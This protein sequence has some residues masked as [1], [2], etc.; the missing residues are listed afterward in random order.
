[1]RYEEAQGVQV[2]K[3]GFGTWGIGGRET[4]DRGQDSE[5]LSALRSALT[6]GY[7]H[8]DTA[9]SYAAGHSEEL[10]GRAIQD[11]RMERT[12]L[13]ITSKAKPENLSA[14]SVVAACEA[15]LRRLKTGYLDLYL[16]HWP[17]RSIPLAETF[18]GMN[19]LK[20]DGKVRHLGVSNFDLELLREAQALSDS[21][22]MA[23]QVPM[24]ISERSYI[25]NGVLGYCQANN[26]LLTAYSPVKHVR[27]RSWPAVAQIAAGR[28]LTES[29]VAI[30]WLCSQPA[31]ITIPMSADPQHQRVNL[32][33]ADIM[34]TPEEMQQLD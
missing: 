21:R 13:F 33:A 30:A 26:I 16:I 11:L 32:E 15:S 4:H 20:R 18:K 8:F 25:N 9:E 6:L 27:K 28:G 17:N 23:N 3:V 12:S 24:S 2:P 7:T 34:L 10:L 14:K 1:M 31:V 22:L 29:Q 19:Q 5:S